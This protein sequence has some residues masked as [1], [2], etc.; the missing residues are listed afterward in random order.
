MDGLLHDPTRH[1][2]LELLVSQQRYEE[3]VSLLNSAIEA[4][5]NDRDA[6]LYRLLVAR[7]LVLRQVAEGRQMDS[8]LMT[9]C[10]VL[11]AQGQW[12]ELLHRLFIR[13]QAAA[14]RF[15]KSGRAQAIFGDLYAW[16]CRHA[17]S[18]SNGLR[19][20]VADAWQKGSPK[21]RLMTRQVLNLRRLAWGVRA[22]FLASAISIISIITALCVIFLSRSSARSPAP[23]EIGQPAAALRELASNQA[24]VI[25]NEPVG[26]PLAPPRSVPVAKENLAPL[27]DNE[28]NS[29]AMP[30][31][32]SKISRAQ[33]KSPDSVVVK[34]PASEKKFVSKDV[35]G[36]EVD[37]AFTSTRRKAE[38]DSYRREPAA[39]TIRY[40]ARHAI[41]VR[42]EPR[43]GASTLET[44]SAGTSVSVL[45]ISGSWAKILLAE[46]KTGFVRIEFL[47]PPAFAE[48]QR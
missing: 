18:T 9:E 27:A 29:G 31:S 8:A 36:D 16:L 37:T 23:Q 22:A 33:R 10:G 43:Y 42:E 21:A 6:Y 34:A 26:A 14:Q 2:R 47:D 46:D 25:D 20:A 39:K 28:G 15:W 44:F 1:A 12:L 41:V 30:A 45:D 3:S 48:A 13:S 32:E 40:T 4:D 17:R 24:S 7:I 5:P 11:R 38:R 19:R 35:K